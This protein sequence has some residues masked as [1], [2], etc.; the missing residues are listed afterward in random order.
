M[1]TQQIHRLPTFPLR[2]DEPAAWRYAAG[3]FVTEAA[4]DV[5]LAEAVDHAKG[6]WWRIV[7]IRPRDFERFVKVAALPDLW[8]SIC[9]EFIVLPLHF[10]STPQDF[11]NLTPYCFE[12]YRCRVLSCI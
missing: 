10:A 5:C 3:P 6:A 9:G 2:F 4:R 8:P 7:G 11:L 1:H 12:P